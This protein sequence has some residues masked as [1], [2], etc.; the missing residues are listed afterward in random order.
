MNILNQI[1]IIFSICLGGELISSLLPFAFPASVIS[2]LL[3][4]TLLSIKIIKPEQIKE[5]SEFLLGIMAFFFIP[6]GVAII[7]KYETIRNAIIPLAVITLTTT[8]I[9]FAVSAY[10]VTF[11]IK[12]MKKKE[13]KKNG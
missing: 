7:E 12:R 13:E 11:L 8:V 6:A 10:T 9:T 1:L 3:L 4:F 5:L 2:L